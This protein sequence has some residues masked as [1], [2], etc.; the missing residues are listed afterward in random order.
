[1]CAC[2]VEEEC[3]SIVHRFIRY[4]YSNW[5]KSSRVQNNDHCVNLS[6]CTLTKEE[7]SILRKDLGFYHPSVHHSETYTVKPPNK[8]HI[9]DGAVVPCGE[10]VLFSEIFF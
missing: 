9:G 2:M 7:T 5:Q 10:V 6:S 8:G 3:S 1:M 4:N